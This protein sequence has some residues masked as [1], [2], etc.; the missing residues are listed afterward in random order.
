MMLD[1]PAIIWAAIMVMML[2]GF[3]LFSLWMRMRK[4]PSEGDELDLETYDKIKSREEWLAGVR[5]KQE[6]DLDVDP[7]E[8]DATH[9][10]GQTSDTERAGD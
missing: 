8:A 10:F 3:I 6:Q 5:R 7:E 2:A 4:R 1:I 9:G